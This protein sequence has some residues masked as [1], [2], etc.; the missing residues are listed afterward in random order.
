MRAVQGSFPPS[1]ACSTRACRTGFPFMVLSINL[2]HISK[3][4]CSLDDDLS[5]IKITPLERRPLLSA[6]ESF[7]ATLLVLAAWEGYESADPPLREPPH[8]A[9]HLR[10]DA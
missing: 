7:S 6:G 5:V 8:A 3:G 9:P 2:L 4:L 1:S 10:W